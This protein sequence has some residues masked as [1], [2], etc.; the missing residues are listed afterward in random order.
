MLNYL[1][2]LEVQSLET[3][4]INQLPF[5]QD[6]LKPADYIN[7][8]REKKKEAKSDISILLNN[9]QQTRLEWQKMLSIAQID[10]CSQILYI[11]Q[12]PPMRQFQSRNILTLFVSW[13]MTKTDQ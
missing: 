1:F 9:M 13:E 7:F 4:K 8:E 6:L 2:N 11:Q 3:I 10:L 12:N 5:G